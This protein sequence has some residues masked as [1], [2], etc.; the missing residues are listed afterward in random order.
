MQSNFVSGIHNFFRNLILNATGAERTLFEYVASGDVSHAI[1]LM[2]SNETDVDNA[3]KEYWPQKHDIMR[4]PNRVPKNKQP[5]ITCKLPRC[6]QRYINEIELFFLLGNPILWRKV[7]GDDEAYKVYGL[8]L[9][10]AFR[11]HDAQGETP[12][13]I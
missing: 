3:I 13:R 8:P 9:R 11:Q 6:R 4:R 5:Y 2:N 12:R 10:A 1:N 7:E